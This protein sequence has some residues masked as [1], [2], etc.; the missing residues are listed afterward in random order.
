MGYDV[1]EASLADLTLALASGAVTS[2]GL[3]Q[4]YLARIEA[5]DRAGPRLNAVV[6]DNPEAL[7]EARESDRRRA[8]TGPSLQARVRQRTAPLRRSTRRISDGRACVADEVG[9]WSSR[10]ARSTRGS[11]GGCTHRREEA[12]RRWA[13]VSPRDPNFPLEINRGPLA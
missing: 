8:P 7:A 4:A 13:G 10:M 12:P 1:V 5:F 6:V 3:V 2:E 11:R 9:S